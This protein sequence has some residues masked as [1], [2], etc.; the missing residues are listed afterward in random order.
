MATQI[1]K[2]GVDS[3]VFENFVY[4]MLENIVTQ[5]QYANKDIVIFM[6]NA[7]MHKHSQVMET[8]RKF[9]V[10]V[11]FNAQYSP[12][13]NPVEQLFGYLKSKLIFEKLATR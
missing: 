4:K 13:L 6:D 12:W 7:I 11:L 2:G 10:N 1:V 3:T 5:E 9:K 8:C